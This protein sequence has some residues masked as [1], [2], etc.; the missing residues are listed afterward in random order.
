MIV[1][2]LAIDMTIRKLCSDSIQGVIKLQGKGLPKSAKPWFVDA[3]F[4]TN[5]KVLMFSQRLKNR[6]TAMHY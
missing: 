4:V 2:D 1:F 6:L 5:S 3:M